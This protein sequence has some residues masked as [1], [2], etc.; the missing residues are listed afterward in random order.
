MPAILE[1]IDDDL[2]VKYVKRARSL[3]RKYDVDHPDVVE[4][5]TLVLNEAFSAE[6]DVSSASR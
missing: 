4:A 1:A 6:K 3:F 5:E 2:D